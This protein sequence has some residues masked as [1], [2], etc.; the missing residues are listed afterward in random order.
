MTFEVLVRSQ[1]GETLGFF[2]DPVRPDSALCA[3][4]RIQRSTM[5]K[6]MR[7][8]LADLPPDDRGGRRLGGYGVLLRGT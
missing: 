7:R 4:F 6:R 3:E 2:Q 8:F 1:H 5:E